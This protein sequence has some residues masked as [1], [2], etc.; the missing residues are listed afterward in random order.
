M[1][2]GDLRDDRPRRRD[3]WALAG[4][5]RR[6]MCLCCSM[7]FTELVEAVVGTSLP[8]Y[9]GQGAGLEPHTAVP[10]CTNDVCVNCAVARPPH[11]LT[12]L[13]SE[14]TRAQQQGTHGDR[15]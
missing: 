1:G 9:G 8:G 5:R 6:L 11:T 15:D 14:I 13:V 3:A 2:G 10:R 7:V 4:R 12:Q